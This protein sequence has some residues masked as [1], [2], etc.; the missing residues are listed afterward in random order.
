MSRRA[1]PRTL[2]ET[3]TSVGSVS[4]VANIIMQLSLPPVGEG[5]SESRV[6][7]GSPRRRPTKR[8]R[9]TMQYL[10][11]ALM[12]NDADRAAMREAVMEVHREVYSRDDSPV[13][14]SGNARDLQLW[15][16]V[17]LFRYYV[18]QYEMEHGPLAEADLDVL[19]REGRTLA[20][21]VN[22]RPH[23]WPDSWAELQRYWRSQLPHLAISPEVKADF[24]SLSDLS[25]LAEAWGPLGRMISRV[26]GK[27]YRFL[28]NAN[29]PPEFRELMGWTWSA[30]DQRRWE[31]IVAVYR[32]FDRVFNPWLYRWIYRVYVWDFRVRRRLG[33]PVLGRL[34]LSDVM[35]RDGG[36]RRAIAG[37]PH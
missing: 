36:G 22:V 23:E 21:G 12:G 29:L 28:T 1:A 16:A 32:A 8:G 27:R 5:V 18:D 2:P 11:L 24:E 14:Y 26:L 31:R 7:S 37:R 30:R 3:F 34:K 4:S 6:V 19:T 35:I 9:T 17:C 10:A 15:V 13:R 33:L 20:T 25:F